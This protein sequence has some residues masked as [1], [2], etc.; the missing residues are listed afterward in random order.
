MG[1]SRISTHL[2]QL[3]RAGLVRDRRA[4]KHIYYGLAAASGRR[5][6]RCRS[7]GAV[8]GDR[9]RQR[10]RNS[11]EHDR[12]HRAGP[13]AYEN[14][15]TGHANISTGWPGNSGGAIAPDARGRACRTCFW[16][17]CRRWSSPTSGRVKALFPNCWRARA[18]QVIAVDNSEKMVEFGA[19]L[20]R[21]HGFRQPRIPPRRHADTAHRTA[22]SVDLA[23]FSQALHHASAARTGDQRGGTRHPEDPAAGW[24]MLDLLAHMGSSRRAN[25]TP[26]CGWASAS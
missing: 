13:R 8:A 12:P 9:H 1:Q 16:V 19:A 20:A 18:R 14:A 23:I 26:T 24:S 6:C 5:G 3:K 22:G 10:E 17:C 21:E 11:R 4:G 7:A 2:A 25:S 15:R